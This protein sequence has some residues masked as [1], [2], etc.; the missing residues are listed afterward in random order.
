MT[1]TRSSRGG[2]L[3]THP[4]AVPL[5][6]LL[7]ECTLRRTRRSGPGGQHRNKVETAVIITHEPSGIHAEANE[8]RSQAQNRNVAIFRLR[9]KLAIGVR[10]PSEDAGV[11]SA[12]WRSRCAGARIQVSSEHPDF[13][14]LLAEALDQ[15]DANG[16][17]VRQTA[18]HLQVSPSQLTRLLKQEPRAWQ[19]VSRGK[20]EHGN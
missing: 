9:M 4:A 2:N 8:R 13:P 5:D 17:N 18:S 15:L 16:W 20:I 3:P 10:Q 19:L 11:P 12:L 6:E 14:A 7:R 1:E